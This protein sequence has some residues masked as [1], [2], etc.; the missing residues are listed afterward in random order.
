[1]ATETKRITKDDWWDI[2]FAL[3]CHLREMIVWNA[4]DEMEGTKR[5]I[6][7]N[8]ELLTRLVNTKLSE[9]DKYQFFS[10]WVEY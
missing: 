6:A 9:K 10:D 3:E 5:S 7:R 8:Q 1:M 2:C 4:S